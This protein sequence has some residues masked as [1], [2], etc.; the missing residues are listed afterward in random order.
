LAGEWKLDATLV[1]LEAPN[2][3]PR[4][5]NINQ[6]PGAILLVHGVLVSLAHESEVAEFG[7]DEIVHGIRETAK[8]KVVEFDATR[9]LRAAPDHVLLFFAPALRNDA[10][11]DR[12]GGDENEG[13]DG[14]DNQQGVAALSFSHFRNCGLSVHV[15]CGRW[16]G[17][18]FER[19]FAGKA[20]GNL[21][22][23]E[24]GVAD[25]QDAIAA[26]QGVP[27]VTI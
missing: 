25:F 9:I 26:Q 18:L 24:I 27:S 3:L 1:R 8:L 10:Q 6:P 13:S 11:A 4:G 17:L 2:E 12:H 5:A 23:L 14:H 16:R 22:K 19:R 15:L 20:A 21:L 7:L